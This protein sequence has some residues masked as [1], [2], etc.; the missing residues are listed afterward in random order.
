[1]YENSMG[2]AME[3]VAAVPGHVP[4][5]A[6]TFEDPAQRDPRFVARISSYPYRLGSFTRNQKCA[7]YT[8]RNQVGCTK[9]FAFLILKHGKFAIAL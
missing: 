6:V 1:M 9:H 2:T 4:D 8:W 3:W 5:Q 7:V